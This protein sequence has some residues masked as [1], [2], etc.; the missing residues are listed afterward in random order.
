MTPRGAVPRFTHRMHLSTQGL[1]YVVCH[2]SFGQLVSSRCTRIQEAV[3]H[4]HGA[5][6]AARP[7]RGVEPAAQGHTVSVERN[8]SPCHPRSP[9]TTVVVGRRTGPGSPTS[10]YLSPVSGDHRGGSSPRPMLRTGSGVTACSAQ[11]TWM[12]RS[13]CKGASEDNPQGSREGDHGLQASSGRNP[14]CACV[15]PQHSRDRRSPPGAPARL[16]GYDMDATFT[17]LEQHGCGIHV[18]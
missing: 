6:W 2:Q 16:G 4:D 1:Q 15:C 11:T 14:R 13:R 5:T 17:S 10:H 12:P 3:R 7:F 8:V 9:P 18:V